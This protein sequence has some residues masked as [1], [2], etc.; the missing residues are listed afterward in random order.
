[1][2]ALDSAKAARVGEKEGSLEGKVAMSIA[3]LQVKL[4]DTESAL[5]YAS[6]AVD[7]FRHTCGEDSPLLASALKI[8]GEVLCAIP[9]QLPQA[10]DTFI[11]AF[12]IEAQKDLVE[13]M[14]MMEL[15]QL[16]QGICRQTPAH[17]KR[18][19]KFLVNLRC[20]IRTLPTPID[21]TRFLK[22]ASAIGLKACQ[23][24]RQPSCCSRALP[25]AARR[26]ARNCRSMVM[27]PLSSNASESLLCTPTT[28]RTRASCSWSLCLY[29]ARCGARAL[30]FYLLPFLRRCAFIFVVVLLLVIAVG[31]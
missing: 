18:A 7:V 4:K 13:L 11:D 19:H 30:S 27:L 1:M 3:K 23:H 5:T 21:G 26:C 24:V 20:C 2:A 31:K 8:K 17:D 10:C 22:D 15:V 29:F 25:H 14:T 9:G 28:C 16:V 12:R 6:L